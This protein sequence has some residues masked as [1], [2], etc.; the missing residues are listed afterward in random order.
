MGG[1]IEKRFDQSDLAVVRDVESLLVDAAKG[2]GVQLIPKAVAEYFRE[3]IHLGRL[4]IQ[5]LML[6]YAID[7]A[8][9]GLAIHVKK[10]THIRTI[11]DTLYLIKIVKALLGEVDKLLQA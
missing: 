1:E 8:F 6:P 9:T 5:L 7:T 11:T 2:K 3:K 4:R 10:V